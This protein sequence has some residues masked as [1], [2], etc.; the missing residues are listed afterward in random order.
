MSD[1]FVDKIPK[2][3][4]ADIQR[5]YFLRLKEGDMEVRTK[6]IEHNLKLVVMIVN[7]YSK[8]LETVKEMISIGVIG[9]FSLKNWYENSLNAVN[10]SSNAEKIKVEIVSGK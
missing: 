5:E 4:P 1:V 6:L 7:K 10:K 8:D 9:F 2:A 3:L